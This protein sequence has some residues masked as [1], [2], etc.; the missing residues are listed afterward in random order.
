MDKETWKSVKPNFIEYLKSSG[1]K[2]KEDIIATAK[3]F[4]ASDELAAEISKNIS[5]K[6]VGI[7]KAA[8][9]TKSV[10]NLYDEA[11]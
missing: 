7:E 8:N 4:G 11:T 10:N 3:K 9:K 2:S 6:S 5:G 1:I